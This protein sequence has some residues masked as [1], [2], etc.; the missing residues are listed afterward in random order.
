[1][2]HP[3]T[4]I[5]ADLPDDTVVW[6][7]STVRE[8]VQ[9]G[10]RCVI[11]SSCYVGVGTSLGDDVRIQD[12]CHLTDH[13]AVG[14]RVFFGPGVV[15]MNDRHPVVNNPAYKREPPI[16]EDDV[17]VGAAAVILPG[18]RLGRG[19]VVGAGAVVTKDVAPGITVIGCP[20]RPLGMLPVDVQIQRLLEHAKETEDRFLGS[21]RGGC[22]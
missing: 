14:S 6:Q 15:T 1:M 3:L 4:V 19:C 10:A 12:K 20:A 13:M 5:Q 11:G 17:T 16:I 18:V 21:W 9:V 2:R 8:G 7:F 22:N